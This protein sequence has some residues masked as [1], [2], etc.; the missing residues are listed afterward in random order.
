MTYQ[1]TSY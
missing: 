1:N